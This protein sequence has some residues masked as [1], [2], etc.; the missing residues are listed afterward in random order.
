MALIDS[1][2]LIKSSQ[3]ALIRSAEHKGHFQREDP[4]KIFEAG[5]NLILRGELVE[6]L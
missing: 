5:L 6:L 1:K 4:A 3:A 2:V